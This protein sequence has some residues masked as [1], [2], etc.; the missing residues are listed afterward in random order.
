MRKY[1]IAK[2]LVAQRIEGYFYQ[3]YRIGKI[4]V[5]K[6]LIKTLK[7]LKKH[8]K[9]S[10]CCIRCGTRGRGVFLLKV[11]DWKMC[12]YPIALSLAAQGIESYFPCKYRMEKKILN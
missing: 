9:V 7:R 11:S 2:S 10:D 8:K 1:P 4:G 12:K 5:E 6:R 3:K